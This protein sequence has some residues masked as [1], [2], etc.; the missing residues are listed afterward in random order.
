VLVAAIA[1]GALAGVGVA[2]AASLGAFDGISAAQHPATAADKL[3]PGVAASIAADKTLGI[4]TATARFITQ[5]AD[6]ARIYVVATKTGALC[7]VAERLPNNDGRND[8]SATG[9]GSPLS[10]S[11]PTTAQSFQP[12][13]GTPPISWGIALDSVTAVSFETADGSEVTVPVKNNVWAYEGKGLGEIGPITVHFDDGS[14]Q[15]LK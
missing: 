7:V 1:V 11:Q 13:E 10:Q 2:I 6:G 9:C 15:S 4:D 3:D 8:A 12:N 14:T 5:F